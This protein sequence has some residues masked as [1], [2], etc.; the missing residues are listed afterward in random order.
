MCLGRHLPPWVW[1]G[2]SASRGRAHLPR[3]DWDRRPDLGG[4]P[5][6]SRVRA[7]NQRKHGP[8]TGSHSR[9]HQWPQRQRDSP[10]DH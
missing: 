4:Q 10:A 3:R 1:K 6:P 5:A 8:D 7:L 2:P 9:Q